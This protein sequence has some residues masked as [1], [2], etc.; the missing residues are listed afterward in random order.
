MKILL[1]S[2][3]KEDNLETVVKHSG[4]IPP[5]QL[6]TKETIIWV[7]LTGLQLMTAELISHLLLL[8]HFL[9]TLYHDTF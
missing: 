5:I 7:H 8:Q 6:Q 1:G 4:A 2:D 3:P 9:G